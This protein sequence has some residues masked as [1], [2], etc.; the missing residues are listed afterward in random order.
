VES[1]RFGALGSMVNASRRLPGKVTLLR[2]SDSDVFRMST[3]EGGQARACCVVILEK[4][5]PVVRPGRKARE[6]VDLLEVGSPA[7]LPKGC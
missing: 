2:G 1:G 5:K 6:R 3:G 7:R 4:G